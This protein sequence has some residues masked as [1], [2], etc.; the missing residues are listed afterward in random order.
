V[1]PRETAP[2]AAFS[3]NGDQGHPRARLALG[4]ELIRAL[5]AFPEFTHLPTLKPG[6]KAERR[7][8]KAA[9]KQAK[10]LT[11]KAIE[12]TERYIAEHSR[13]RASDLLKFRLS[14]RAGLRA[15][16]IASLFLEDMM[17]ANRRP[18]PI[19]TVRTLKQR[20]QKRTRDLPMHPEIREALEDLLAEHPHAMVP[21]FS[22]GA[23]GRLKRQSA[24]CITNWFH[25]L[26]KNVGL[27]DCSSHSGRRTFATEVARQLSVQQGSLR[28]LQVAMGHARIASTESYLEPSDNMRAIIMGLGS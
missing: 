21:A 20:Y 19:I 3:G 24:S 13:S 6:S 23:D 18:S 25:R 26:Y 8:R 7:R 27:I 22:I 14:L 11:K 10:T 16:E 4:P 9:S 15:G 17:E 1:A 12:L 2:G 28:D 5:E